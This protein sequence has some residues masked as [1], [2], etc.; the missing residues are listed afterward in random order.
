[1]SKGKICLLLALSMVSVSAFSAKERSFHVQNSVR[2]GYDDNVYQSSKKVDTAF[3]TD[4][5]NVSGKLTFSSRSDMLLYWQP[6]FRYRIDADPKFITYQ[7]LYARFNHAVSQRTFIKVSDRLRYQDKDGQSDLGQTQ[8]QNYWE[9]DLMG[10]VD[11]TINA[12]SHATLGAGYEFRLWD[13]DGY[14]QWQSWD[15]VAL[16]GGTGGNNYNQFRANGS[17]VRELRPNTTSGVLDLNYMDHSYDG[18]RGGF[19][20]TTISAGVDQ[21]FNANVIGTAR[22]GYSFSKVD[23]GA[24]SSNTSS[25]YL[26]AGLEVNPTERTSFTGN[27][28]YSLKQSQ[29]SYYNAQDSF[30]LGLGVRHDLTG[31]ISLS[32]SL[33]YTYSLYDGDYE[34]EY[35]NNSNIGDAKENYFTFSLR[36]SYQLNRNNFLDAGY[37]FST[38]SSDSDIL[39]EFDRNLVDIGWR[40][41]F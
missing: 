6:E 37:Q 35:G 9:N 28:G 19:N 10:S 15:P 25:P 26:Q 12:V 30:N 23:N 38:R 17:Y 29:N 36:G 20:S 8:N 41:R 33:S 16:T 5:I 21:N 27:L 14:G 11:Y 40:L 39:T 13:D 22:L 1:M 18:S 3:I 2:V 34:S 7:D 24:G 4:I 32:S 31:K